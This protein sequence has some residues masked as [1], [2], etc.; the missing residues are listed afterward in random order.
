MN[1]SIPNKKI[2]V[3]WFASAFVGRTASGT[4]QTAR[5]LVIHLLQDFSDEVEVILLTKNEY[6]VE[7]LKKDKCFNRAQIMEMPNVV[8]KWMKS[9]RQFYKFCLI[10][11]SVEINILHYSVPRVYPFFWLFPAKKIVC[12]FHAGGD[13]TVPR[14]FFTASREI[15][16]FI[17]K[18]QWRNF[19]AIVADS[20]FASNEISQ[21]YRIPKEFITTIYLGADNLWGV[22]EEDFERD[23]NLV[24]VMG[25]W[26]Y[27]KNL[28]TVINAFKKFEVLHNKGLR[29]KVIGKSGFINKDLREEAL[30]GFPKN[31]IELIEYLSDEELAKE[32]RKA[33]VVFHPSIN[34]GFGLPA[35]EAFG[36]GARLVVHKGTPAD[37]ILSSQIGVSSNNLLDEQKVIES[38]RTIL[39]QGFGDIKNRRNFIKSIDA[40]WMQVAAKY[41]SLYKEVLKR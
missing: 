16:N 11:R 33:T 1:S 34:E 9:S 5:K 29:L 39:T 3:A 35:F 41:V 17:V 26:Q 19:D 20:T 8:G 24:L 25:R 6:E 15:Y 18:K 13:V 27:Y 30:N 36:E 38:Y 12:T 14:D 10:N 21:A 37:E 2:R 4:A 31:Q 23:L 32:Y 7:L 28:H 22:V 40:T